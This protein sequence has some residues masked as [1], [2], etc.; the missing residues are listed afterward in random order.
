MR[1]LMYAPAGRFADVVETTV[2]KHATGNAP[3]IVGLIMGSD[4]DWATMGYAAETLRGLGIECKARIVSAH[5]T[6][7]DLFKYAKKAEENGLTLIIAGAGGAAHL[8]GMTA[9][10]TIV[11]VIGVPVV[12]TP[13]NGMDAL[14][15]IMQM[16]A[17]VGVATMSIGSTGA[18]NA[19]LLA[20]TI[21]AREDAQLAAKLRSKRVSVPCND[22][23]ATKNS[24]TAVAIFAESDTDLETMQHAKSQFVKLGIPH[25]I[26][27][28]GPAITPVEELLC[29]VRTAE[30]ENAA[31]FIAGSSNGIGLACK[32][33]RMT[34]APVFGVPI[35]SGEVECVDR[36]LQSFAD[37][38]PGTA[39]F[40][41]GRAGAI[42][43]ALFAATI[44]SAPG[45]DVRKRLHKARKQQIRRV[46]RMKLP[47]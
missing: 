10:K 32:I 43:A 5:R 3:A 31:V 28:V 21:L 2:A 19:A 26:R 46:R 15:S 42:N 18:V 30:E 14:L 35:V 24:P 1:A 47:I 27:I 29:H 39:T 23:A 41:I 37:M 25:S 45:S 7:D 4:S 44:L 33:A 6:P 9:S 11:P 17:E 13:L 12:T 16:P 40:A 8:P 36:F 20:A 38:P 22:R 34:T